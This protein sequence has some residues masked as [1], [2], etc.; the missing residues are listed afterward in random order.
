VSRSSSDTPCEFARKLSNF[1]QLGMWKATELRLFLLYVGPVVLKKFVTPEFYNCFMVLS[2]FIRILCQFPDSQNHLAYAKKLSMHLITLFCNLFGEQF[3]VYNCHV[4]VHL[5]DDVERYGSLEKF[6]CFKFEFFLR[7]LLRSIR[8]PNQ[9]L[10]Q[11]INR[12]I[13]SGQTFGHCAPEHDVAELQWEKFEFSI[14]S[15]IHFTERIKCYKKMVTKQYILKNDFANSFV[16]VN[17]SDCV[18]QLNFFVKTDTSNEIFLI[19]RYYNIVGDVFT[20]PVLSRQLSI[21]HIGSPHR[22]LSCIPISR[23]V[24]K[25]FVMGKEYFF[26]I[27]HTFI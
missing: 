18:F 8:S 21:F 26:P 4:L 3:V 22:R 9:P 27:I 17:D 16:L 6:S 5:P 19:G 24:C 13:E 10:Q 2:V 14:P 23:I 11:L 7:F 20:V 1:F 12:V 25:G 15:N